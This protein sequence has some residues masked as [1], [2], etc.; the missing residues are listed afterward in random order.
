MFEIDH[1]NLPQGEQ[2][3]E[4]RQFINSMQ[5][6]DEVE[7]LGYNSITVVTCDYLDCMSGTKC[8]GHFIAPKTK[9][10]E[11]LFLIGEKRGGKE[12]NLFKYQTVPPVSKQGRWDNEIVPVWE[13]VH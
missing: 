2:Y 12:G 11:P 5:L 6:R 1:G 13:L 8:Q 7:R 3:R 10:G 9:P 4:L